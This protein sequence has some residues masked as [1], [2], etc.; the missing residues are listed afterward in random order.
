MMQ[1]MREKIQQGAEAVQAAR[2]QQP[3][4]RKAPARRS[5]SK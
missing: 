1:Q 4:G 5:R 3:E 2:E